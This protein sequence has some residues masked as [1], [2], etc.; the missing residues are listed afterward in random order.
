LLHYC[1]FRGSDKLSIKQGENIQVTVKGKVDFI[2]V[3]IIYAGEN[4]W[5]MG[6]NSSTGET[7]LFPSHVVTTEEEF[8]RL[9]AL[10]ATYQASVSKESVPSFNASKG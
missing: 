10:P 5:W 8:D 2:S 3:Q 9:I 4:G 1:L 6:T 7:G